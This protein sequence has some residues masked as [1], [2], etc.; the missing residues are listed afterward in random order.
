M[1]R[2]D[3]EVLLRYHLRQTIYKTLLASPSNPS[4]R[5]A[6]TVQVNAMAGSPRKTSAAAANPSHR[7]IR[8]EHRSCHRRT[9]RNHKTRHI[10]VRRGHR[11]SHIHHYR[12]MMRHEEVRVQDKPRTRDEME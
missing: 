7:L 1:H 10:Q 9:R 5:S 6:T 3:M 11:N 4:M 8:R 12:Q 2:I